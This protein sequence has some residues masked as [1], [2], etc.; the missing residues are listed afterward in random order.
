MSRSYEAI[1]EAIQ[2]RRRVVAVYRERWV[3]LCPHILGWARDEAYVL[4]YRLFPDGD[5]DLR[6]GP[7]GYW[8][9]LRV[10]DLSEIRVAPGSWLPGPH[11]TRPLPGLEFVDVDACRDEQTEETAA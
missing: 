3:A 2:T 11:V 4:A 5:G 7:P 6:S 10:G 1:R 8:D 9:R